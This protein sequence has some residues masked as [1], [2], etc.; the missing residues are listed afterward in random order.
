VAETITIEVNQAA[1]LFLSTAMGCLAAMRGAETTKHSRRYRK[2]SDLEEKIFN[3]LKDEYES[4]FQGREAME[5]AANVIRNT[6][7]N[8]MADLR[9]GINDGGDWW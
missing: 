2:L 6:E 7:S 3:L 4:G 9:N 8:L 1:D 5:L